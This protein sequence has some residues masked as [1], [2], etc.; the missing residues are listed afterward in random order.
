MNRNQ[1]DPTVGHHLG[2][3]VHWQSDFPAEGSA[4]E[5]PGPPPRLSAKSGKRIVIV[6]VTQ[7]DWIESDDNCSRIWV[8]PDC[9]TRREPMYRLEDR[10]RSQGFTRIS[11][12]TIV[13]LDRVSELER[14]PHGEYEAILA[15]GR[16]L[17][18][19]RS[20]ARQTRAALRI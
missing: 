13:N 3:S 5:A 2:A 19:T 4:Y 1:P 12:S 15:D 7:I 6:K 11:R 18:I 20:Y 14:L 10:L 16:Q 17:K 8:G 9:L